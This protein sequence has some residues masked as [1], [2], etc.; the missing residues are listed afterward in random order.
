MRRFASVLFALVTLASPMAVQADPDFSGTWKLD[1]AAAQGP[2][3]PQSMTLA[4]TQ[5]SNTVKIE[6]AATTQMGD[7]QINTVINLDGSQ[8]KNVNSTPAGDIEMTSTAAWDSSALVVTTRMQFQGQA[9]QQ[10]DR[11]SLD[12]TGKTLHLD[13]VIGVAGQSF[14][15]KLTFTK[16]Q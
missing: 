3:A 6:S 1:M 7:Q 5:D 10:T 2:M 13:R 15:L 9:V 14:N 16:R 8:S 12:T 11:W 4:I